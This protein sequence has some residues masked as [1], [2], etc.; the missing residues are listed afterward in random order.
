MVLCFSWVT[1]IYAQDKLSLGHLAKE[2]VADKTTY[3]FA[4]A[5]WTAT[6]GDWVSSQIWFRNG[7][8]ESNPDFTINGKPHDLPIGFGAGNR[9]IALFT[10]KIIGN[11]MLTNAGVRVGEYLLNKRY[12]GHK[13][14]VAALGWTSRIGYGLILTK[15][16]TFP[17]IV[18]WQKNSHSPN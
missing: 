8:V 6:Q 17:H 10:A 16:N 2:V 18:Q 1:P 3:V 4:G 7:Y 13:R 11:T 5:Y 15:N 9:K 12:P 14:L